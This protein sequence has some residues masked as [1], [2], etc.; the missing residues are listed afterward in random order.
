MVKGWRRRWPDEDGNAPG[1]I[2]RDG[3]VRCLEHS[4]DFMGVDICQ[5]VLIVHFKPMQF[6]QCQVCLNK[7]IIKKKKLG[8]KGLLQA[9]LG[10]M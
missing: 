7:I 8:H 3:D 5:N 2:W 6:I 10:T 9:E 1:N 4:H